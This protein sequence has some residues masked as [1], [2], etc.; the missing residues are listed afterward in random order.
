[1]LLLWLRYDRVRGAVQD[2]SKH[3]AHILQ[4]CPHQ[5][6]ATQVTASGSAL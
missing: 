3:K 1:M 5:M 4:A 6:L 2:L